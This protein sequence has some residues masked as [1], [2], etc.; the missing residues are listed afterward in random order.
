[1]IKHIREMV[2][3]RRGEEFDFESGFTLIELLI[4]IVVLGIWPQRSSSP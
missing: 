1:M 4:V 2:A 3:R